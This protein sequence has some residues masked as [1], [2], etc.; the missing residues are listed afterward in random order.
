MTFSKGNLLD[1]GCGTGAPLKQIIAKLESE[2]TKII[3]VDLH[4]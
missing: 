1:V 2:Y 3:G 4:P